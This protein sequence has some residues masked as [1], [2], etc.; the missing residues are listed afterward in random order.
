MKGYRKISDGFV[1]VT[2]DEIEGEDLNDNLIAG[3]NRVVTSEVLTHSEKTGILEYKV[4][5]YAKIPRKTEMN[6]I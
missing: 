1:S 4:I 5:I 3:V 6:R 2:K